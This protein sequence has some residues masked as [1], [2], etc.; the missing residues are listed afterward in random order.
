MHTNQGKTQSCKELLDQYKQ[1]SSGPTNPQRIIFIG[2][3]DNDVYNITAPFEDKGEKVIAGRVESRDSESS[4]VVFF[5]ESGTG[6]WSPREGAPSFQMQDPFFTRIG[7][8]LVLG[9]VE[10]FP[11]PT[12]ENALMWRTLFYKGS[13]IET[14]QF[15]FKGPDEMKDLRIVELNDGSVGVFTRPQ[16]E[17]GG[18]GKIG[19]VRIPSIADLTI[20]VIEKAPLL[21]GQFHDDEWGGANELH[22]LQDGRIGVLGH[23]ACFDD[24]RDR[25]YYP[26]AFIFDPNTENYSPMKLIAVRSDFLSGSAK[27]EFLMD[28]VFSGG[29]VRQLDG[30]AVFYAGISDAEGHRI[31]IPDPFGE[32]C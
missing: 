23:I 11:H 3:G 5:V 29:L 17:K 27:H 10:T 25:H 28:V 20:D 22:V 2:V 15:F 16:G 4:M 19:Y 12:I 21:T 9:G 18:R 8:D 7:G 32:T 1:Q 13:S 6:T 26:M 24:N 14:L 30:T 31:V